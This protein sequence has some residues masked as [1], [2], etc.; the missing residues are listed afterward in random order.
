[1]EIRGDEKDKTIAYIMARPMTEAERMK[2]DKV[3][4]TIET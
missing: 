3:V 2:R 4:F 1:M